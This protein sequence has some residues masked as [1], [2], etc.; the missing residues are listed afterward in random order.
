VLPDSI[1]V[2]SQEDEQ[3]YS[4]LIGRDSIRRIENGVPVENQEALST[5][6]FR[7]KRL[8]LAYI[9]RLVEAKGLL[10]ILDALSFL[11]DEAPDSRFSLEV[12]GTGPLMDRARETVIMHGLES[13]VRFLGPV[14]GGG[15]SELF[16]RTD[17]LVM[18]TYHEERLP[19]AILEAMAVGIPPVTCPKAAIAGL[20]NDGIEGI[21]VQPRDPFGLAARLS[22]LSD[23]IARLDQMSQACRERIQW[24]YTSSRMADEFGRLYEKISQNR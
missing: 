6:R 17:L 15:L 22:S 18:P 11:K 5:R 3:F 8:R 7:E 12:A 20:V 1:V 10:D 24:F 4:A 21:L 16:E 19:Y 2:I 9:G 14:F 23:D 13:S